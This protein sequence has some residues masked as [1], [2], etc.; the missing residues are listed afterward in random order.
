MSVE[1]FLEFFQGEERDRPEAQNQSSVG[2]RPPFLLDK[3]TRLVP[4]R[5]MTALDPKQPFG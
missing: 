3:I 5:R 1:I 4:A 2:K